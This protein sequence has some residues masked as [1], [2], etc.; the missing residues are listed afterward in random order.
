[1]STFIF[2]LLVG[3]ITV[4]YFEVRNEQVFELQ[5]LVSRG[6]HAYLLIYINQN[7]D[8]FNEEQYEN[9]RARVYEIKDRYSYDRMLF[10][11]RSLRLDCWYTQDE[12]DII[13]E[14]LNNKEAQ[15]ML[16]R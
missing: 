12:V 1:M 14:G 5:I 7:R 13:E 15:D 2:I 10:S 8:N 11:F 6:C 9:L 16:N 3:L 4:I